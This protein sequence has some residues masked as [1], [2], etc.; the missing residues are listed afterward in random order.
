MNSIVCALPCSH[1]KALPFVLGWAGF[2]PLAPQKWCWVLKAQ[3]GGKAWEVSSSLQGNSAKKKHYRCVG[4]KTEKMLFV[5]ATKRSPEQ[6]QQQPGLRT[7][8]TGVTGDV[9]ALP[10]GQVLVDC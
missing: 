10:P 5:T 7:G 4:D 2:L 8:A 1:P 6:P 9:T 3:L